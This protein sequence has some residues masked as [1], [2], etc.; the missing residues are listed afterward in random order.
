MKLLFPLKPLK[1]GLVHV[2]V[3]T[4]E[5]VT[6]VNFQWVTWVHQQLPIHSQKSAACGEPQTASWMQLSVSSVFSTSISNSAEL[7]SCEGALE[8][9]KESQSEYPVSLPRLELSE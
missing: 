2:R 1:I 4:K 5:S 6:S 9:Q 7:L 8:N 3:A